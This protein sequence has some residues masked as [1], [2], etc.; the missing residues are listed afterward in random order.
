[1]ATPQE[2][3]QINKFMNL[4]LRNDEIMEIIRRGLEEKSRGVKNAAFDMFYR[5]MATAIQAPLSPIA[6]EKALSLAEDQARWLAGT[7]ITRM[8][9]QA[10]KT[11]AQALAHGLVRGDGID[12]IARTLDMVTGLDSNRARTLENYRAYLDTLNLT[13]EKKAKYLQKKSEK[14]LRARRRTIARTEAR[15][16]TATARDLEARG[17]GAKGKGWITVGDDRVSK[18]ICF[19]NMA[20]GIIGIDEDFPSGHSIPPG[21]PDC[22]CSLSYVYGRTGKRVLK[23]QNKEMVERQIAAYG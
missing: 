11:V 5:N 8:S 19:N 14:L 7:M 20:A 3:E 2:L 12:K 6:K 17:M 21:H 18:E 1:M 16:A 23:E 13:D 9:Q 10:I 15:H 22:R 4:M